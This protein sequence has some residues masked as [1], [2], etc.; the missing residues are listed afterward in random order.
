MGHMRRPGARQCVPSGCC[1]RCGPRGGWCLPTSRTPMSSCMSC[2]PALKKKLLLWLRRF[3]LLFVFI[4]KLFLCY[5]SFLS[6]PNLS[7]CIPALLLWPTWLDHYKT[8]THTARAAH[9]CEVYGAHWRWCNRGATR[10]RY[11]SFMKKNS[12]FIGFARK[13]CTLYGVGALLSTHTTKHNIMKT[14]LCFVLFAIK[15]LFDFWFLL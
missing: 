14:I 7:H 13:C 4:V 2:Y 5:C 3:W 6:L 12:C 9:E 10:R 1:S 15:L 8:S 11:R